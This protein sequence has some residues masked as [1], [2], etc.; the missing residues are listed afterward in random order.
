MGG[1]SYSYDGDGDRTWRGANGQATLYMLDKQAPLTVVLNEQNLSNYVRYVHGLTGLLAQQNPAGV[2]QWTL[3]DGLQSLRGMS[4]GNDML[5]AQAYSPYGEPMF[6]DMP[7]EFGFTGEQTDPLNDLVYLRARY[8]NPKLGIFGSLDPLE[9]QNQIV[10]SLNRYNWVRGNVANLRDASG[11]APTCQEIS[12]TLSPL[13]PTQQPNNVFNN[14]LSSCSG[15]SIKDF[16]I[17]MNE[18]AVSIVYFGGTDISDITKAVNMSF[19]IAQA[20]TW[21]KFADYVLEYPGSKSL[22]ANNGLT[23]QLPI[24]TVLD[25]IGFSGGADSLLIYADRMAKQDSTRLRSLVLLGPTLSGT[26]ETGSLQADQYAE[27]RR[28]LTQQLENDVNILLVN[29]SAGDDPSPDWYNSFTAPSSGGNYCYVF[30]PDRLHYDDDA[31]GTTGVNNSPEFLGLVDAWRRN[32]SASN[33]QAIQD[34]G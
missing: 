4:D 1:V 27:A 12:Q 32:P 26:T 17:C 5:S 31:N 23:N 3:Q 22:H 28:I 8:M 2:F 13:T 14:C 34:F 11:M 10:S 21:T 16:A 29:D 18:C 33:C 30:S 9:G 19:T 20:P 15:K 24:G 7:T 25:G 6:T